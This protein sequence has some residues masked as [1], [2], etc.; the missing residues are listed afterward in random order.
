MKNKSKPNESRDCSILYGV[1]LANEFLIANDL[2]TIIR[3]HE[4]FLEGYKTYAWNGCK[5]PPPVITVFSAPNYCG[6]CGN[7]GA[8]AWI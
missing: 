2:T 1:E 8:V 7:K 4:V 6:T 3:G 5:Q